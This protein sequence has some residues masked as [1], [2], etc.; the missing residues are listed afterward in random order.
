MELS[1]PIQKSLLNILCCPA[2]KVPV[3][4]VPARCLEQLNQLIASGNVHY[5]DGSPVSEALEEALVTTDKQWIYRIDDSIPV[6]LAER[7]IPASIVD[8]SLFDE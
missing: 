7:A 4:E 8:R 1:M 3:E 2:T 5:A 6:M